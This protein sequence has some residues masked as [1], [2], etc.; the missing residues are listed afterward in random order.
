MTRALKYN[1]SIPVILHG[2]VESFNVY[3]KRLYNKEQLN[4]ATE[5][6]KALSLGVFNRFCV[7]HIKNNTNGSLEPKSELKKK[8]KKKKEN[9][10]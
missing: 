10:R 4:L 5:V 6:L 8:K 2:S 9:L 1:L 3:H 7:S